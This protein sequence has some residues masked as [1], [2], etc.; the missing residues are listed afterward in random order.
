MMEKQ[1]VKIALLTT[2]VAAVKREI[3]GPGAS[4][5]RYKRN[6]RPDAGVVRGAMRPHLCTTSHDAKLYTN[7]DITYGGGGWQLS[8]ANM[9]PM[10]LFCMPKH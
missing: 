5:A 9:R 10:C 2:N 6:G 7:D 3:E 1:D 8:S 4:N